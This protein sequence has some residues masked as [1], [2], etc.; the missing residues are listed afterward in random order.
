MALLALFCT[1]PL[2][3]DFIYMY[4]KKKLRSKN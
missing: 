2:P 4:A 3:H 1:P